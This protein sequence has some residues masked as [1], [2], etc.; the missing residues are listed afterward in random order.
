MKI[1]PLMLALA[2]PMSAVASDLTD[3]NHVVTLGGF[4]Y[5][6]KDKGQ[7]EVHNAI[8]YSYN[9][10]EFTA[11]KNS[12]RVQSYAISYNITNQL[13]ENVDLGLRLGMTTGYHD[14]GNKMAITPVLQPN[15]TFWCDNF[16][17]E[18]GFLP[19]GMFCNNCSDVITA[20]GKIRF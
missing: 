17:V 10:I 2:F 1:I 20:S 8:G 3:Y 7:E 11:Y 18:F 5:H 4:S 19:T 6:L 12:F 16:G 13:S 15:V 14:Y 9:H